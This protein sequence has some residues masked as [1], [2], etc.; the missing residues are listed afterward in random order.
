VI[1][2][3]ILHL[4]CGCYINA[5][6]GLFSDKPVYFKSRQRA[7]AAAQRAGREVSDGRREFRIIAVRS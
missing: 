6:A 3:K 5:T 7:E 1:R 4:N 2:Y